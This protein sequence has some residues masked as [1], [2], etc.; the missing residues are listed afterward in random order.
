MNGI[1][2]TLI[3]GLKIIHL[4][5]FSDNRG[6]FIKVFNYDFFK[7]NNLDTNLNESY[8]SIS[9]KNVIRGMHFQIP[10]FEHTKLVFINKGSILD[11]VIDIRSKSA[12]YKNFIQMELSNKDPKLVY[13]PA[14]CAHGFL[15]LEDDTIVTYLQTSVY[16]NVNDCGIKYNSFGMDWGVEYPIISG[17]DDLFVELKD[18]KSPF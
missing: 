18:F 3:E 13:I 5:R 8:F 9:H 14:G 17:R 2:N 16:N 7:E 10:P 11:V 1:E 4:N 6:S 15:S 12:T